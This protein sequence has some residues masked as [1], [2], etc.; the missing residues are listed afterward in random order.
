MCLPISAFTRGGKQGIPSGMLVEVG[1]KECSLEAG[2]D[3]FLPPTAAWGSL[4]S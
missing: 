4:M 3:P 2:T 1:T